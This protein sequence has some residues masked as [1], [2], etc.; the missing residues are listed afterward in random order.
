MNFENDLGVSDWGS[1]HEYW[2]YSWI[3]VSIEDAIKIMNSTVSSSAESIGKGIEGF[4]IK[5]LNLANEYSEFL[6][7]ALEGEQAHNYTFQ[8]MLAAKHKEIELLVGNRDFAIKLI[9][10]AIKNNRR[11]VAVYTKLV[12]TN[13][14]FAN[15]LLR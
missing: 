2:L 11:T 7:D 12:R 9:S 10:D 3:T 8:S 6:L 15:L 5:A 14:R 1:Y 13:S 4:E